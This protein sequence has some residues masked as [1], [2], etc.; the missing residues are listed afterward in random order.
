MIGPDQCLGTDMKKHLTMWA[1]V[2]IK[3]ENVYVLFDEKPE[4]KN[5]IWA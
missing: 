3:S 4:A 5:T 1:V 2:G